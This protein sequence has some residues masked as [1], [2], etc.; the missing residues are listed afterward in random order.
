MYAPPE[1]SPVF[2][3]TENVATTVRLTPAADI[4]SLAKSA[5]VLVTGESPRRFSNA[6]ISDLPDSVRH[7]SWANEFLKVLKKATQSNPAER[8]QTVNDFWK[9]LGQVKLFAESEEG[10]TETQV[11]AR[12]HTVPQPSVT[13]D[14]SPK[15]PVMPKF[16]TSRELKFKNN[17]VEEANPRLVV[18][19]DS[20]KSD[21]IVQPS[22]QPR[23]SETGKPNLDVPVPDTPTRKF[24]RSI[25]VVLVFLTM[26]AA[27][28][29]ATQSYLR[30]GRILPEIQNPFKQ[31]FG[32]ALG[33]VNLRKE[34][35]A[36][37]QR[38]GL[39][40]KGSRVR[41]IDAKDNWIK[42]DIIEFSHPKENSGDLE[43]GWVNRRY[44]DIQEQ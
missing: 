17:T 29:F 22:P 3:E 25:A 39:V 16:N 32:V 8:Q 19:L 36:D 40:P 27:G 20:N 18:K 35:D 13:P 43:T 10:E 24:L 21:K 23:L 15:A 41:I 33:D 12:P 26:V 30:S 44:I 5:Y 7:K 1:H 37:S 14:F 34:A 9:D 42:I 6:P 31:T 2:L 28:L 11:S 4:Y 38:V